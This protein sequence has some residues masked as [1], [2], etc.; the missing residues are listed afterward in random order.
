MSIR[1]ILC[2][3][4]N[5]IST[6]LHRKE[7]NEAMEL[8]NQLYLYLRGHGVPFE[9][10]DEYGI[11]RGF[12]LNRASIFL[13]DCQFNK[14]F[15]SLRE[16]EQLRARVQHVSESEIFLYTNA[17][18]NAQYRIGNVDA[19][20][21]IVKRTLDSFPMPST[22]GELL[23][24]LVEFMQDRDYPK[25]NL[26]IASQALGEAEKKGDN[27]L[28]ARIYRTIAINLSNSYPAL[29]L[30][31]IRKAENI[32]RD[33]KGELLWETLL[34][35]AM[36]S[37]MVYLYYDKLTRRED[38]L[39]DAKRQLDLVELHVEDV[40]FMRQFFMMRKGMILCDTDALNEALKMFLDKQAYN[41]ASRI[42]DCLVGMYISRKEYA[43]ALMYLKDWKGMCVKINYGSAV[44]HINK[45]ETELQKVEVKISYEPMTFIRHD[46]SNPTI[47][48]ILENISLNE[49]LWDLVTSVF[50]NAFP[51]HAQEGLF[52]TCEMPDHTTRLI[53]MGLLVNCYYRGQ[54]SFYEECKPS[55][56]RGL[57]EVQ[58][59]VERLKYG[60][61]KVVMDDYPLMDIYRQGLCL[62]SPDGKQIPVSLSVDALALAQHYGIKTE[63]MDFTVD[64]F[65]AA[66]FAVADYDVDTDKY[67]PV[68]DN[69]REG[70]FYIYNELPDVTNLKAM[71]GE[72][73]PDFTRKQRF[74]AVGL[75]PFSRPGE[76]AGF[77][78][79]MGEDENLNNKCQ[80]IAFRHDAEASQFIFNYVNRGDKLFPYDILQDKAG[81]IK[82]KHTK[83][84]S[85][86]AY[87]IAK[88][89]FYS[90]VPDGV[91]HE[92]LKLGGVALSP[93]PLVRFTEKDKKAFYTE[94]QHG[95]EEKFISKIYVRWMYHGPMHEVNGNE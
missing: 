52:E 4:N 14:V 83:T 60:E 77:V 16:Y 22:R 95:G 20:I 92:F 66:F 3:Y 57:T 12:L 1:E 25:M 30:Y 42:Y 7:N 62:K 55:F 51:H 90:N 33:I 11:M 58:K 86:R 70:V 34:D 88:Q 5:V 15:I 84:F 59:F 45:L 93:K 91:L 17:F 87:Q 81:K 89:E 29:G 40:P 18:A 79:K 28:M 19:A 8:S 80:K 36:S 43:K 94:W 39:S 61:L 75:Q 78:L 9:M 68:T 23:L 72:D 6:L 65:V 63:L 53:P 64:K 56:C 48:D 21:A 67:R 37:Y 82:D 38:F 73:D 46:T 31:F 10:I 50:R 24:M 44:K 35:R 41:E 76:Q 2:A 69:T 13:N 54:S 85:S 74:R 32:A 47:L 49:E 27:E 71:M 26:N